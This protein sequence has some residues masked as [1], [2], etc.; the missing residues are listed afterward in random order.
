MMRATEDEAAI[1]AGQTQILGFEMRFR[2]E[3]PLTILGLIPWRHLW[4]M[5]RGAGATAFTRCLVAPAVAGHAMH[6]VQPRA[7]NDFSEGDIPGIAYHRFVSPDVFS[8]PELRLPARLWSRAWRYAAFQRL[9]A[10]AAF[11]AARDIRPDLIVAYDTMTAPVARRVATRLGVP[12]VGR[13]FGNT[14]SLGLEKKT[15]WH[16]NFME[17]IGFRVP[18]QAM[19][20]TNDGSPALA[21][22]RRLKVDP[23][24]V[25]FLRN[26]LDFVRFQ[27]GPRPTDLLHDLGLPD[28]AFVLVTATRFHSEKRLDRA[29]RALAELRS[30]L[31]SAYAILIGDGPEKPAIERLARELGVAEAVR[32]PGPVLNAELPRWYRLADVVLSLLDRTNASN[33]VF[34]A[35]ACERCV[36]AL[37]VGTTAEVVRG[38]VTGMLLPPSRL[39]ELPALL[40]ELARDSGRRAMLGREARV[41]VQKLCGSWE[42]RLRKEI[43]IL[44]TVARTREI[45]PGN[46]T[47]DFTIREG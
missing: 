16:G 8:S 27:P 11:E 32:F 44:E 38:G 2:T 35:M 17:R 19:I 1:A 15:R 18:V 47:P 31:P 39:N 6:L 45:L 26:G 41:L 30:E 23:R 4:S 13:Y 10:R 5:G 14:L 9:A 12:L 46:I 24:P 29:I 22:L 25:H 40:A 3:R 34:E 37:D 33:P 7:R 21:V 43:A 20:L 36:V 42:E 28:D